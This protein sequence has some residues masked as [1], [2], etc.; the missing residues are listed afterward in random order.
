MIK[1]EIWTCSECKKQL[2]LSGTD[3]QRE[4]AKSSHRGLSRRHLIPPVQIK[5]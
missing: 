2:V 4:A 1:T 3:K 5:R